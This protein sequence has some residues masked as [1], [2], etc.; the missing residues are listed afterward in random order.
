MSGLNII[1][2]E[3]QTEIYVKMNSTIFLKG[4]KILS[5]EITINK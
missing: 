5:I 2:N 1:H 4:R 3:V